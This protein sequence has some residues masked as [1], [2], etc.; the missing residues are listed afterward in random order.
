MRAQLARQAA[1]KGFAPPRA[2]GNRCA[3]I[4]SCLQLVKGV[5][6]HACEAFAARQPR[7]L[8]SA[9]QSNRCH[10]S[11]LCISRPYGRLTSCH[12]PTL[13]P[14]HLF[15]RASP[16]H[17]PHHCT[18]LAPKRAR[19]DATTRRQQRYR[20]PSFSMTPSL[21]SEVRSTSRSVTCWGIADLRMAAASG[22]RYQVG[23]CMWSKQTTKG[24]RARGS[25]LRSHVSFQRIQGPIWIHQ[26]RDVNRIHAH[27]H[28]P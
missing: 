6:Q 27:T 19:L 12:P 22:S 10:M 9:L 2:L 14:H 16:C 26:A 24:L 1:G 15:S 21:N 7:L 28:L 4:T 18:C 8:N 5:V 25:E 3:Q 17:N 23:Q 11:R 20:T 13:S